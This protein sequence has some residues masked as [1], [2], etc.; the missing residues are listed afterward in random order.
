MT[1]QT[2]PQV[3]LRVENLHV[4][5][6][7]DGAPVRAV[8][9]ISYDLAPGETLAIVGESG[10]GKTVGSR[11]MLGLLPDSARVE[12]SATLDDTQL[13]GLRGEQIRRVR[14]DRIAMIFQE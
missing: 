8:Q 12:G 14:G 5:F 11:A 2:E 10:S 9:G 1:T 7:T 3:L 6:R 13:V 4:S